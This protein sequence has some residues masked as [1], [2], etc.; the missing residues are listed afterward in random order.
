M[1]S[2]FLQS[3]LYTRPHAPHIL[4]MRPPHFLLSNL[5]FS[6]F[7]CSSHLHLL[8]PSRQICRQLLRNCTLNFI[9]VLAGNMHLSLILSSDV[10]CFLLSCLVMTHV[11]RMISYLYPGTQNCCKIPIM[12]LKNVNSDALYRDVHIWEDHEEV[13]PWSWPPSWSSWG[14]VEESFHPLSHLWGCIGFQSPTRSTKF[15]CHWNFFFPPHVSALISGSL[16]H[17]PTCGLL[18]V[19]LWFIPIICT[20]VVGGI[21]LSCLWSFC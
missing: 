13:T 20:P 14:A 21:H 15:F 3:Y 6:G 11:W 10:L 9:F 16:L 1:L 5:L 4:L 8:S 19:N 12:N 18:G 7:P 2:P 17:N